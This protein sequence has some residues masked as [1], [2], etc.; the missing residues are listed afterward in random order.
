MRILFFAPL[1]ESHSVLFLIRTH[2]KLRESLLR[3]RTFQWFKTLQIMT[4]SDLWVVSYQHFLI[5]TLIITQENNLSKTS[6]CK[7]MQIKIL[8]FLILARNPEVQGSILL[9]LLDVILLPTILL[10]ISTYSVPIP[11]ILMETSMVLLILIPLIHQHLLP[12]Q[13]TDHRL[14]LSRRIMI[15]MQVLHQVSMTSSLSS[16]SQQWTLLLLLII[17]LL[18]IVYLQ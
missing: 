4:A 14:L 1:Q 9:L 7:L 10:M 2:L 15:I 12:H 17:V 11:M 6:G 13:P 16:I 5:F 18:L 8:I 3:R